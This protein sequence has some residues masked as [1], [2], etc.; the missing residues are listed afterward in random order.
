MSAPPAI[1]FIDY[2]AGNLHSV[3]NALLA[4]GGEAR[5]VHGPEDLAGIKKLILPGVGSFGDCA[6]NLERQGLREPLREWIAA[7]KPYL[8]ICLGYQILFD[9]SEESPGARGLGAFPGRSVRFTPQPGLKIP[10]MGWNTVTARDPEHPMWRGLPPNPF[11]YFVHSYFPVPDDPE[12]A[13]ATTIYGAP[14]ACAIARGSC[15]A[16]QFHPE[17]SQDNGL[18]LLRHFLDRA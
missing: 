6:A 8:G 2:G 15:W 5:V 11:F 13:A 12:L 4:I 17:R 18:A 9:S 16:V 7:G 14:F 3:R 10:H 1:G